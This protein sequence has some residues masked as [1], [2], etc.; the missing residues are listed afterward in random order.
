MEDGLEVRAKQFIDCTYE[1]DLMAAAGVSYTLMREGNQRYGETY[2]GIHYN[3]RFLPR[4]KFDQPRA[5]GRLPSGDTQSTGR[6][7]HTEHSKA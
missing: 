1:G 4:E 5:N 3:P 7:R 6:Q 2:N